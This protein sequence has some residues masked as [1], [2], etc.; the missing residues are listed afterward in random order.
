MTKDLLTDCER[1]LEKFEKPSKE[2]KAHQQIMSRTS[3]TYMFHN[4]LE[5]T[6]IYLSKDTDSEIDKPSFY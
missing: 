5:E 3:P 4:T 2:K 1:E 6:A